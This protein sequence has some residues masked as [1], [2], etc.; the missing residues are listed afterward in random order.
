MRAPPLT[1]ISHVGPTEI[2]ILHLFTA[3]T[4]MTTAQSHPSPQSQLYNHQLREPIPQCSQSN[5]GLPPQHKT[6]TQPN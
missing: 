2:R 1:H 6:P 4:L 3:L 5:R